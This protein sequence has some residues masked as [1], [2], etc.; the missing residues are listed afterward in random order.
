M[1]QK[2]NQ[3]NITFNPLEDRLLMRMTT[4][5]SD[6]DS[7]T[8]IR[9]WLTRRYTRLLWSVFEKILDE[10]VSRYPQ[11]N[12]ENKAAIRQLQQEADLTQADFKTPYQ[13]APV[14]T[15]LGETPLLLSR[16]QVRKDPDG[17]HVLNLGT[18][19][20]GINIVLNTQLVHSLMKL[21]AETVEK[22]QWDLSLQPSPEAD[23]SKPA[24]DRLM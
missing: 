16:I 11:A 10:S 5:S 8:E 1:N 21:L 24:M 15:P 20:Q 23:F 13:S 9:M 4:G 14:P 19:N 12:S 17:S 2:L 18:E 6:D 22:A 7:L 3:I